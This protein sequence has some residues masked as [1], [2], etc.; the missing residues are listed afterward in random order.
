LFKAQKE[1]ETRKEETGEGVRNS[2]FN[3]VGV[4]SSEPAW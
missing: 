2:G 1:E 4:R 3:R